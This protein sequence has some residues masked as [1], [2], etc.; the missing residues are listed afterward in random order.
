M[1]VAGLVTALAAPALAQSVF[2]GS[3]GEGFPDIYTNDYGVQGAVGTVN[4]GVIPPARL[5]GPDVNPGGTGQ[6][7]FG[8]F[9]D[10]RPVTA[11]TGAT[12]S[13][14]TN[15][16]LLNTAPAAGGNRNEGMLARIR[17]RESKTSQEVL[18][19][20][21]VLSCGQVWVAS[22]TRISAPDDPSIDGFPQV[23]SP[24]PIVVT[25]PGT[26]A[27]APIEYR[28]VL[29][30]V[31]QPFVKPAP[32]LTVADI[33]RG[34][35]EV[36]AEE[37]L[38]CAPST[39][40]ERTGTYIRITNNP[41]GT[42]P[43][44]RS[45]PNTLAGSV[46]IVRPLAGVSYEYNM[47]A[48]TRF[49]DS[50]DETG[51]TAPITTPQPNVT[52]SCRLAQVPGATP[53]QCLDS[54]DFVLSKSRLMAQWDELKLIAGQSYVVVTQPTKHH[55]CALNA[56]GDNFSGSAAAG[57]IAAPF[58]CTPTGEE[59]G[60]T[61][62]DRLENFARQ[63]NIFSPATI[64]RCV[65][66]R[67]VTI[68]GFVET[69]SDVDPRADFSITYGELPDGPDG[70]EDEH[71]WLDINLY[72]GIHARGSGT[73]AAN[74]PLDPNVAQLL[75]TGYGQYRGLPV[76]GLVIQEYFNGNVGGVF[77]AAVPTYHNVAYGT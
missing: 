76:I 23:R 29:A 54:V 6:L 42:P 26:D 36:F 10:V 77:G 49:V 35:F 34:Y 24:D 56:A 25:D 50:V 52:A 1:A 38:P 70:I 66:P 59:V 13:Q 30:T 18:D 43:L 64:T 7:L 2:T 57:F 41:T 33:Q 62:Y 63:Q 65:L 55:H 37:R 32:G 4:E 3:V 53:Q 17:F 22:I 69:P 8:G 44:F 19:F 21:I 74:V 39:G 20:N 75:G 73:P 31:G 48:I 58:T 45:P 11:L 60:C 68:I 40:D 14:Q 9:Y 61:I 46:F 47:T 71:G 67:E 15:I 5:A 51:I 27:A 12:E 16:Q 72:N 28:P